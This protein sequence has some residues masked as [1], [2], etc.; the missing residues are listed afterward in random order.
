MNNIL[1]NILNLLDPEM[2]HKF[3]IY[4][5]ASEMIENKNLSKISTSNWFSGRV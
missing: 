1:V 3:A 4:A 5:I 2:A